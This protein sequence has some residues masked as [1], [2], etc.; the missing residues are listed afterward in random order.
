MLY[1][2]PFVKVNQNGGWGSPFLDVD[3]LFFSLSS[4]LQK[5]DGN[6]S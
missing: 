4:A 6:G 2:L 1:T 3:L 5:Q